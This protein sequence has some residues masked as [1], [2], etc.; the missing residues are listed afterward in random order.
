[1]ASTVTVTVHGQEE[2]GTATVVSYASSLS[3]GGFVTGKGGK[4]KKKDKKEEKE[5]EKDEDD[6]DDEDSDD[7]SE[8]E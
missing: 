1:M 6:D 2:T 7:S 4:D 8:S 5:E 3:D